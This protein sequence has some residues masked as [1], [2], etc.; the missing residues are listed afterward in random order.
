MLA[1]ENMVKCYDQFDDAVA[2]G[3][4]EKH[5]SH[6]DYYEKE[7]TVEGRVFGNLAAELGL[8]E[9]QT[10]TSQLFKDLGEN[11]HP[12]TGEYM[13][14]HVTGRKPMCDITVSMPKS[15]SVQWKIGEDERIGGYH[16]RAVEK[17]KA[18]L[19][20][21]V[22][23]QAH[24]GTDH[25][26]YTNN[27]VAVQYRHDTNRCF[28]V[29]G[30]DHIILF[31]ITRS[32]NGKYYAIDFREIYDWSKYLTAVYRDELVRLAVADGFNVTLGKEN[33]PQITELM[34]MAK[35]HQRRSDELKEVI[36]N[37][38]QYAGIELN[39][40]ER[41]AIV[42]ASRGLDLEAFKRK[43]D[44]R[45]D[46]FDS[47]KNLD[48]ATA[49]TKRRELLA[50]FSGLVRSCS[51]GKLYETSTEEV[52]ASQ[53][54]RVTPEQWQILERLKATLEID[55]SRVCK[56][57]LDRAIDY[58]IQKLFE[59]ESVIKIYELYECIL[60]HERGLG[61]DPE[62]LRSKVAN[63]P[64]LV[65]GRGNEVGSAEHYRRELE[66]VLVLE[67][68]RSKGITVGL[69]RLSTRLTEA[70]HAALKSLLESRDQFTALSGSSGVGKTEFVIASVIEQN[71]KDGHRVFVVAPSDNARDVL[72][73][74]AGKLCPHSPS[75]AVL[76]EAESLQLYQAD[77]RLRQKLARGDLLIVDEASFV[78][79]EQGH[80]VL[81]D[82]A[83]RG[84]RVCFIGDLDQ[85]KSI[86]AGDF[87]R[88]TMQ[89]GIH[90][91]ELHE[92][93]RQSPEALDGHYLASVKAF[94]AGRTTEAFHELYLAGCIRELRG[95]DRVEAIADSV[96]RSQEEGIST[97]AVSLT[98]REND[99]VAVAVRKRMKE[100]GRLTDTRPVTA[101]QTLG[102]TIAER[103]EIDKLKAGMVLEQTCGKEKGR[104]WVIESVANGRAYARSDGKLRY[105]E[106]G[107]ARAFDVCEQRTFELGVGDEILIRSAS[108]QDRIIN[109]ERLL[110]ASWDQNGNPIA[111]DGRVIKHRNFCYGYA[112]TIYRVQGDSATKVIVSF[113]RHSIRTADRESAYVAGSRGREFCEVFVEQIAELAGIQNRSGDRKSVMEMAIAA[114]H[115]LE[116]ELRALL[117][118]VEII[119]QG[120]KEAQGFKQEQEKTIVDLQAGARK[121]VAQAQWENTEKKEQGL[122]G[123]ID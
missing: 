1:I 3:L 101:Y 72:R 50:K 104:A 114:D 95:K 78:S 85:E 10:I 83:K 62:E 19:V 57:D 88:Q 58:A 52:R 117:A 24:N 100:T 73:R 71:L 39:N 45:K 59:R 49:E 80:R 89:A 118:K 90:T 97:I 2:G 40:R 42:R 110:V 23:R 106:K 74:D 82:A 76:Q 15:W 14:R 66:N 25:L 22:G 54:V 7:R 122:E 94:K 84:V 112:S 16:R 111:S 35:E 67:Q 55:H 86:E 60:D 108:K 27:F 4:H 13:T 68:G 38:E 34:E 44:A 123:S 36:D 121:T 93:K 26:E 79:L 81:E 41:S 5:Y 32:A 56:L 87:F 8:E 30:H 47:L 29:Q 6:N 20:R 21:L 113:D 51:D 92:I 48:P 103:R 12:K 99:A 69:E 96:I 64:E 18:E 53:R 115:E 70:Q 63:R 91:A 120:K 98:H 11:R 105:F 33:E 9:G 75:A 107:H 109:G 119:Q 46:E 43:W 31:N 102:W 37:I 77:P 61:I 28:E 65:F 116:P 17:V